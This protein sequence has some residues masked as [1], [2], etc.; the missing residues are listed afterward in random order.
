MDV[1][2]VDHRCCIGHVW[3]DKEACHHIAQYQ[4]LLEL[5]EDQCD[6]SGNNEDEGQVGDKGRYLFHVLM[7]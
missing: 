1:L 5:F 7:N 4:W 6:D 3:T 2:R